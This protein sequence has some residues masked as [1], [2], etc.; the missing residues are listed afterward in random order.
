MEGRRERERERRI[1]K[2]K[3]EYG[4]RDVEREEKDTWRERV[5]EISPLCRAGCVR[6]FRKHD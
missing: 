3:E 4:E 2:E 1:D 5:S 6:F